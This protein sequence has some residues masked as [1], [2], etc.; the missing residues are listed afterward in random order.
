VAKQQDVVGK[1][2]TQVWALL[3]EKRL[4]LLATGSDE[5]D[6]S[7]IQ[8][9]EAIT[10]DPNIPKGVR[11]LALH[12]I[13]EKQCLYT[14][15]REPAE[16]IGVMSEEMGRVPL[17]EAVQAIQFMKTAYAQT[18]QVNPAFFDRAEVNATALMS[19][20]P[21][22]QQLRPISEAKGTTLSPVVTVQPSVS[23]VEARP[24]LAISNPMSL[25]ITGISILCAIGSITFAMTSLGVHL[26]Q[27]QPVYLD[28]SPTQSRND[29]VKQS[30]PEDL[31]NNYY[32][33]INSRDYLSA[34][35]KLPFSLRNDLKVHPKGYKS[36]VE[37]FEQLRGIEVENLTIV[38][39]S[40]TQALLNA[41]VKCIQ[42][43]GD[44]SA[45]FLRFSLRKSNSDKEWQIYRVNYNPLKKSQCSISNRVDQ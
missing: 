8:D 34:W 6:Y 20:L 15:S 23:S 42:R 17:T 26:L 12:C 1:L 44:K 43:N 35:K 30:T 4:A 45:L 18:Y 13:A 11:Y 10:N 22:E 3:Q 41:D 14:D 31:V 28:A 36:F 29:D 5:V 37:F 38:E 32:K 16:M 39:Q 21:H 2:E 33:E 25:W 9:Y 24:K 7:P 40:K 27:P 19:R